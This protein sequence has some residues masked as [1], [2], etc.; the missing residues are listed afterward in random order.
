MADTS[1][2]SSLQRHIATIQINHLSPL[3]LDL[4]GPSAPE[5]QASASA[6]SIPT[7]PG[8][9]PTPAGNESAP[10]LASRGLAPQVPTGAHRCPQVPTGAASAGQVSAHLPSPP[11]TPALPS[12]RVT[13]DPR[14]EGDLLPRKKR[15]NNKNKNV[16]IGS[17]SRN[18]GPR[19]PPA[20]RDLRS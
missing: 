10:P 7:L 15:N 18:G 2:G 1:P 4:P 11:P 3:G 14:A 13:Q 20:L 19:A 17:F 8:P 12:P 6:A 5:F 9:R 16:N